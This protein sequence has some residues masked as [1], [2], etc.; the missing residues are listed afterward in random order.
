VSSRIVNNH[1]AFGGSASS[2]LSAHSITATQFSS[3]YQ[4]GRDHHAV[5][6]FGTVEVHVE[7]D[8]SRVFMDQRIDGPDMESSGLKAL[9]PDL[10]KPFSGT[11]ISF[12][13]RTMP[14]WKQS[15]VSARSDPGRR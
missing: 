3:G 11:Q 12:K 15:A 6:V 4:K 2:I 5:K 14:R 9:R 10:N 8:S 7:K 13:E 1:L